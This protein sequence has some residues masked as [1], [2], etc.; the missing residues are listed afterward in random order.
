MLFAPGDARPALAAL[1]ALAAELLRI[2]RYPDI[3]EIA[4]L[5][6]DWWSEELTRPPGR[7]QHPLTRALHAAAPRLAADPALGRFQAALRREQGVTSY[8][9]TADLVAAAQATWQPVVTLTA[10][11]LGADIDAGR[12]A[13]LAI[14]LDLT[15]RLQDLGRA[16]RHG[17]QWLPRDTQGDTGPA[18]SALV[19]HATARLAQAAEPLPRVL[20]TQRRFARALLA[21]LAR[22]DARPFDARIA[23]TPLR[24]ILLAAF[25]RG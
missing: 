21:E 22:P 13:D 11:A 12:L 7:A 14:G 5:R 23:L 3:A 25:M 17:R 19:A 6:L 10:C 24:M 18:V 15:Q 9:T 8:A 1:Y 2:A 4:A 20:A 16:E